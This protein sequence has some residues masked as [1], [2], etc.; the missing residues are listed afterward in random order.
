[1]SFKGKKNITTKYKSPKHLKAA[2]KRNSDW[3]TKFI[4]RDEGKTTAEFLALIGLSASTILI[5][6]K[7]GAKIGALIGPQNSPAGAAIGAIIG[8]GVSCFAVK[9]YVSIRMKS[10]GSVIATYNRK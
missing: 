7:T 5:C 9:W 4:L 6:A 1:M 8:T 3:N 10:D 2:I